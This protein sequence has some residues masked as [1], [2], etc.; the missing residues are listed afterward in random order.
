MGPVIPP[1]GPVCLVPIGCLDPSPLIPLFVLPAFLPHQK[2]RSTSSTSIILIRLSPKKANLSTLVQAFKAGS[3]AFPHP[4]RSPAEKIDSK[5]K[6]KQQQHERHT[7]YFSLPSSLVI[8]S[9][10]L[11]GST[12]V[13]PPNNYET[14]G[15]TLKIKE[16]VSSRYAKGE[17]AALN[18]PLKEQPNLLALA[19]KQD[20]EM[21]RRQKMLTFGRSYSI[22]GKVFGKIWEGI[23][24]GWRP[25]G[26]FFKRMVTRFDED[27]DK[28]DLKTLQ[29]A[30][31]AN[32]L[33]DTLFDPLLPHHSPDD[34][35]H[36]HSSATYDPAHHPA[37]QEQPYFHPA[38]TTYPPP[39]F[40]SA[41]H[42]PAPYADHPPQPA[43]QFPY[44]D[45]YHHG[46]TS[47]GARHTETSSGS[48]Q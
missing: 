34:L 25:I 26:S 13:C 16:I 4:L 24:N 2:N 36:Q 15:S 11:A 7:M 29:D 6:E 19:R 33:P 10:L 39:S 20:P 3:L 12:V 48:H 35:N 46:S 18:Q 41:H 14:L 23:K 37:T 28:K 38:Q 32:K 9:L 40:D 31:R 1:E 45:F 47:S 44:N 5:K 8:Y 21:T 30:K 22:G 43:A 27:I 17:E 42:Y